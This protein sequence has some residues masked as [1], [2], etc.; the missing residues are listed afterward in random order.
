MKKKRRTTSKTTSNRMPPSVPKCVRR[1]SGGYCTDFVDTEPLNKKAAF[2]FVKTG[3]AYTVAYKTTEQSDWTYLGTDSKLSPTTRHTF[4]PQPTLTAAI[5][6]LESW[7]GCKLP[8][9]R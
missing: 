9:I 6:V 3:S 4:K 5:Q 1:C 7:L 8:D 2:M